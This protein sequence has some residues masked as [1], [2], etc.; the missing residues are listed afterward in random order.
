MAAPETHTGLPALSDRSH[1]WLRYLRRKVATPD[2]WTRHGHPHPH[3]DDRSDPP[4]ASWH[5][6]D[7]V[8]SSYAVGL[9][10]RTTPAWR[11][12]YVEILDG[13][14]ERHTAWWSASD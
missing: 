11:E 7:L 6:F 5:R 12:A 9:M 1:G 14:T 2:D 3:W 10:A 8:D 4:M 13:M